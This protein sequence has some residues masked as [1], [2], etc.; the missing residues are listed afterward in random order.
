MSSTCAALSEPFFSSVLISSAFG[1][2][3]KIPNYILLWK[4]LA[5]VILLCQ[6]RPN[7][8]LNSQT[9]SGLRS[10]CIGNLMRLSLDK[11]LA[12]GNQLEV[13]AVNGSRRVLLTPALAAQCGY[14]MES[15]PWGNTRIYTSLLGCFVHNTDDTTFDV[16]LKLDM[17]SP[18]SPDI[19]SHNV[20]QSCSYSR[21]A[22]REVLCERNYMEVS[23]H[24]PVPDSPADSKGPKGSSVKD[25][26][27]MNAI[28]GNPAQGGIWKLTFYTP[29]AVTMVQRE[30]EQAGYGA[31]ST[32]S[33]LVVRSPYHKPETYSED[34][35]GIP[36][37]VL[38]VSV[39]Y[40]SPAGLNVM[41][42]SAAC[43]IGGVL[44]T[45]QMISW[46][47][48]RSVTPLVDSRARIQEM[49]MGMS[50]QRLDK[51][52]LKARGYTLN[53]KD[54]HI[55]M[56][57]PVGTPDGY[58]KSHAPE[59]QYH[60]TFSVE[61][62][63]EV[64]WRSANSGEETQT[65]AA[66]RLFS[67]QVGTFL[68]DVEL[69]NITFFT[70]TF[71][72]EEC[73]ARGFTVQQQDQPDGARTFTVSLGFDEDV[74]KT[75]NPEP[76]VT[77]YSLSLTLGFLIQPELSPFSV[78]VELQT[79][80]QDVVLPAVS[81]SC[82][83]E[84][85]NIMVTYGNQGSN[86][87]T[88]ETLVGYQT[89]T[90]G[91]AAE[92]N[93]RENA[94]H[95]NFVV[96]YNAQ[97]TAFEM[98][99]SDSVRARLDVILW[100]PKNH[101]SVGDLYLTCHFPLTTTQCFPNGTMT[102]LALKLQSVPGLELDR[103]RLRDRSCR[104]VQ[105]T[106]RSA[107][108]SFTV[109]SCGT[110]RKF[111]DN[112]MVYENEISPEYSAAS[113]Y[114]RWGNRNPRTSPMDPEYRQ[115]VSCFYKVDGTLGGAFSHSPNS[116]P[117]AEVGAGQLQVHMRLA[118]DESYRW[119]YQPEDFPVP[120]VLQE[121]VFVEVSLDFSS[122]PRLELVLDTCWASSSPDRN[123]LPRWDI[124]VDTCENPEDRYLTQLLPVQKDNRVLI[125]AHVK[126]FSIKMFTFTREEQVLQEQIHIH[127]DAVVCDSGEPKA[128]ACRGQCPHPRAPTHAG[129]G[130]AKDGRRERSSTQ[131]SSGPVLLHRTH[132]IS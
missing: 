129:V 62:M 71:T 66:S 31:L 87:E 91:S 69:R 78:P 95:F 57:I 105:T 42:M 28:P 101:W 123:S 65:V 112:Y 20:Q 22:Q 15:D 46:H 86:F 90:A 26:S 100:D 49:H 118:K 114:P 17:F 25:D 79:S 127:C 84:N 74:V 63:L 104:P 64:L 60:V 21:W 30:A 48:P 6:A 109:D 58:Y 13:E 5:A 76:L 40:S 50:G 130:G 110:S 43:P 53:T 11:A 102:A 52:E 44:F 125:P 117:V 82:D 3:M 72:V 103:L 34:V 55:V 107:L 77:V 51:S 96:P 92:Y 33:R 88:F 70:G 12:V 83:Q 23:H 59:Y 89:L 80:L 121:S 38:R 98:L 9:T 122:D 67:V 7:T 35:A 116:A 126:R 81:G 128:G 73:V 1:S 124:I 14:S 45:E 113:S 132:L 16:G 85:F 2:N 10:E 24:I 27:K 61:P 115:R 119:F 120:K 18:S 131:T 111:L 19:S 37:E 56:E 68:Q 8:K 39:Y 93:F 47:V 97:D 99:E 94:T 54:F 4:L 108:F 106:S 32:A 29:E 36:M 41:D 75:H